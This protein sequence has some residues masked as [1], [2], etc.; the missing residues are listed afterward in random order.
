MCR[1][2]VSHGPSAV[3]ESLVMTYFSVIKVFGLATVR[4]Y[5][6][7]LLL[8]DKYKLYKHR[9]TACVRVNFVMGGYGY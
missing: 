7:V 6:F 2:C 8:V 3:A 5:N 1:T 4:S 9:N